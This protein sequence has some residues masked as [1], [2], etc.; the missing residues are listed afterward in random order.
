MNN[1]VLVI[2]FRKFWYQVFNSYSKRIW[3]TMWGWICCHV[4]YN[5]LFLQGKVYLISWLYWCNS[6]IHYVAVSGSM[7]L[8]L[9]VS[10]KIET[11]AIA[12]DQIGKRWFAHSCNNRFNRIRSIPL[13]HH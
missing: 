11:L 13:S 2:D 3:K 7:K 9:L 10:K 8:F 6:F 5:D 12:G 4:F 1:L